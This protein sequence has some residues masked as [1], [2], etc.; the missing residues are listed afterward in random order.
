MVRRDLFFYP[1]QAALRSGLHE[2]WREFLLFAWEEDCIND[3]GG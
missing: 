3:D 2:S 1:M